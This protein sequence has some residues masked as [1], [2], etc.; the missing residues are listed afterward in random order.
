MTGV[1]LVLHAVDTLR[2]G[3]AQWALGALV[4][5]LHETG[6]TRNV[7]VAGTADRA[8]PALLA[9]LNAHA[10]RV[11]VL[12]TRR[13]ADPAWIAGMARAL[14]PER[15]QLLHTHLVGANVT[16][17]LAARLARV[18]HVATV[19][20]PPGGAE[21]TPGRR[22]A[23]GV[24][25]RSS[26]RIVAPSTAVAEAYA[27]RW[28]L[29]ARRVTVL[30]NPAPPRP[31]RPG[32]RAAVRAELGIGDREVLVVC[33]ARL[34]AQKGVDVLVQAAEGLPDDVRVVVA[35]DG[36]E[37]A[38]LL[39]PATAAGVRL[40]GHRSDVADLLAAADLLVLPSRHEAL[41]LTL[42]EAMQAG[43]PVVASC[44]GG[45]PE[46][47]GGGAGVL[48]P[49]GAAGALREAIDALAAD[50]ARRTELAAAGASRVAAAHA[51]A[52][53]AR[54]HLALYREVLAERRDRRW[55]RDDAAAARPGARA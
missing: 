34:E 32:A 2:T 46:L 40:L 20:T 28:R 42:L 30:P 29:P 22:W 37:R 48:V 23:D 17:R 19:H 36:P 11:I 50:R 52:V 31:A 35:G 16:G 53:V 12:D 38:A 6:L 47:L 51:P 14:R 41:P 5:G 8:D 55:L 15:P 24:T 45:I 33:L 9:L 7:V 21:D 27:A 43:V 18:P 3:G 25:A 26:S 49:P 1:P 39:A 13:L 10:E 44:V 4:A 54:A